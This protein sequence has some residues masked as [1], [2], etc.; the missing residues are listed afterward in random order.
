MRSSQNFKGFV[1]EKKDPED[2]GKSKNIV[3]FSIFFF[4]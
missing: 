2:W 3:Y 1:T 4:L